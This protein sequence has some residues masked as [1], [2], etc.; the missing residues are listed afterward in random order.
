MHPIPNIEGVMGGGPLIKIA[1]KY[2]PVQAI[3]C[4]CWQMVMVVVLD[5]PQLLSLSTH[6][7]IPNPFCDHSFLVRISCC[8]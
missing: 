8:M 2:V 3:H 5:F 4:S 6:V 7:P 1:V